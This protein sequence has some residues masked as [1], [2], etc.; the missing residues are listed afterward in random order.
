MLD[1]KFFSVA[2][3][4]TTMRKAVDSADEQINEFIDMDDEAINITGISS[5]SFYADGVF[6]H[7]ITMIYQRSTEE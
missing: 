6:Y 5:Q 7:T 2:G 3:D 1:Q 4:G